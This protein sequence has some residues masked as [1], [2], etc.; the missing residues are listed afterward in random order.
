MCLQ[1]SQLK[2]KE[3]NFKNMHQIQAIY[4]EDKIQG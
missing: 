3:N 1:F 2:G 4:N